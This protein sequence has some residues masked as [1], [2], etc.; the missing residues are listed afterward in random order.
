MVQ[1][2]CVDALLES[3]PLF[4]CRWDVWDKERVFV[5]DRCNEIDRVCQAQHMFD[6]CDTLES[7]S[8]S[9]DFLQ[10]SRGIN[11]ISNEPN[12]T[13]FLRAKL[14]TDIRIVTLLWGIVREQ[15]LNRAVKCDVTSVESKKASQEENQ[16]KESLWCAKREREQ[17]V[18]T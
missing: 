16:N 17:E 12:D 18:I 13:D 14:P 1:R 8:D 7:F 10:N 5:A 3:V 2:C 11:R 6:A 9:G 15:V 4:L